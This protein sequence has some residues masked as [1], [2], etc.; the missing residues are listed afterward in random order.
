MESTVFDF[1]TIKKSEN[2]GMKKYSDAIYKGELLSGK[3]HGYG[4]MQYKKNRVYEGQ[5]FNDLR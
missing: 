4:I 3:R 2:F 5:W 1:D